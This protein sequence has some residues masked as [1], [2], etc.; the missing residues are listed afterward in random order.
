MGNVKDLTGQRF[1]MW[2]VLEEDG[3]NSSGGAMWK[4]RCDCGLIKSID[5]R[6]LRDG[7]SRSCGCGRKV[8]GNLSHPKHGGKKE[9]L[10]NVWSGIKNR[11][12]NPNDKNYFRYGERGITICDEWKDDYTKFREWAYQNGYDDTLPKYQCTIDRIDNTQGYSPD[13]C[14]FVDAKVQC[15]NRSSNHLIEYNGETHTIS[16][17]ARITGIGKCCIRRRIVK[18]GWSVEDA[19]TIPPNGKRSKDKAE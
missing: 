10:Y 3:R 4:C 16:E 5:G 17:W 19:L 15:N 1:C 6:S 7:T 9:R 11:C 18:Q 8:Y 14:R 13:N 2:V 12:L